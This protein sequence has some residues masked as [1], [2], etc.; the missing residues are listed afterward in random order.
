MVFTWRVYSVTNGTVVNVQNVRKP[1]M[2][3][4][5]GIYARVVVSVAVKREINNM[6]G[7]AVS[8]LVAVERGMNNMIG[9]VVSVLAVARSVM[10]NMIG[11]AVYVLVAVESE[12]KSMIGMVVSVL[13]VARSGTSITIGRVV[14]VLYVENCVT[15]GKGKRLNIIPVL[16]AVSG[17]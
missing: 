16:V 14:Y 12:M 1:A 15:N 10:N 9:M 17:L 5:T 13:A 11:T 3:N 6:I 8:V 4:T 7:T 2:N